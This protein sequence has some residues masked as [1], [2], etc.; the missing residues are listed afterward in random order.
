MDNKLDID[1][2]KTEENTENN[3]VSQD[4][5]ESS[6]IISNDQKL[7]HEII[8]EAREKLGVSIDEISDLL[9]IKS[10]YLISI[11]NGDFDQLPGNTYVIGFLK[12]YSSFL[13]LNTNE[14][15]ELYKKQFSLNEN[16][17]DDEINS[18]TVVLQDSSKVVNSITIIAL[19]LIIALGIFLSIKLILKLVDNKDKL[20]NEQQVQNTTVV[21]NQNQTN[22]NVPSS[23]YE[24]TNINTVQ[25]NN[26]I[27]SN[28]NINTENFNKSAQENN[29]IPNTDNNN[30]TILND[31][32]INNQDNDNDN[33]QPQQNQ[34]LDNTNVSNV[35]VGG[36][37]NPRIIVKCIGNSW[38]K[39]KQNGKYIY[40][41]EKGDVGD[42]NT[43]FEATLKAGEVYNVPNE[44]D[45]Y[46]TVGNAK[47]IEIYVDG[48][49]IKPFATKEGFSK[50]NIE[51][52]PERLLQ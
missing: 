12:S 17:D 16:N 47:D 45:I 4:N 11:E 23:T 29:V 13:R 37:E 18:Q 36:V 21:N 35:V 27:S 7:V 2:L 44:N 41:A 31:E 8:K 25:N 34:Q 6:S 50:L 26:N 42:G 10:K 39:V 28:S 19:I 40:D 22:L 48:K 49:K 38:V 24:M 43:I 33:I 51:M 52:N 9:K 20:E 14:I 3:E 1:I 46:L 30:T 32:V 5:L 15:I